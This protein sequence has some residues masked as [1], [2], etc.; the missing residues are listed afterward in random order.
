MLID[1]FNG[2]AC[3]LDIAVQIKLMGKYLLV[4]TGLWFIIYLSLPSENYKIVS[5]K[6]KNFKEKL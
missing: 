5:W 4:F 2:C 1:Y 6:K 3:S